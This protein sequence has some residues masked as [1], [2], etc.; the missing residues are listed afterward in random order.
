MI[1]AP[2]KH[3]SASLLNL[4][5]YLTPG[6]KNQRLDEQPKQ[7]VE[8]KNQ[9]RANNVWKV[10]NQ[11]TTFK[12]LYSKFVSIYTFETKQLLERESRKSWLL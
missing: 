7:N 2:G 10:S 12:A 4:V 11:K 9:K 1:L 5:F 8:W 6:S 3:F